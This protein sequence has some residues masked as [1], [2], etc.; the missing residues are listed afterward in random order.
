MSRIRRAPRICFSLLAL[1]IG[2]G[3]SIAV[4]AGG[5]ST[6]PSKVQ[7]IL[8]PA[9]PSAHKKPGSGHP[10][11]TAKGSKRKTDAQLRAEVL[12]IERSG[13]G[14]TPP[15]SKRHGTTPPP[16]HQPGGEQ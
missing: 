2:G 4:S 13:E 7:R 12:A 3:A 6:H 5:G 16:P 9:T 15:A 11:P 8:R 10:A 1:V 14:Y